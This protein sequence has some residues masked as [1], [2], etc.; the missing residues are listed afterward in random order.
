MIY[1]DPEIMAK[2]IIELI[3]EIQDN[4][5]VINKTKY[6]SEEDKNVTKEIS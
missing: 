4:T 6:Q 3:M 1:S 2:W 5:K